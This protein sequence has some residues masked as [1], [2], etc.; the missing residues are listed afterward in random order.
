MGATNVAQVYTHWTHLGHRE[1]RLLAYLALVSL[2]AG[3]PPVYFGGWA[4]AARAIGLD[5]EGNPA[6]AR[7]NVRQAFQRLAQTGALVSSGKAHSGRRAE[8]A[9]TLDPA[10]S[11][12]ATGTAR[13]PHGR[14]VTTWTEVERDTG[15]PVD[16]DRRIWER[17]TGT[18]PRWETES[19]SQ[20][21]DQNG[22]QR[23]TE[24]VSPRRYKDPHQ[25]HGEED[26]AFKV[27]TGAS[28]EQMHRSAAAFLAALPDQGRSALAGM[29]ER[30]SYLSEPDV[31]MTAA[32]L[33]GWRT[34]RGQDAD[35][36]AEGA[37]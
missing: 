31:V 2:D 5:P 23:E 20:M 18:V 27:S 8:Y 17:E 11:V 9:L 10:R 1:A 7:K 25:E 21:G 12:V 6:S 33:A 15:R 30:A 16:K 4:D 37:A 35:E 34:T 29:R 26:I 24:S 19:V 28:R 32:R 3:R 36:S 22:A 13:G 14:E